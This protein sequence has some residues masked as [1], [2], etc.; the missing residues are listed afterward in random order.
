MPVDGA[1]PVRACIAVGANQGDRRAQ[2]DAA[3]A[4]LAEHPEISVSA[5]SDWMETAPVGPVPQGDFINGAVALMTT[6]SAEALLSFCL[7]IEADMGRVRDLRWGPRVID[8]DL[9][10]YGD[11]VIH[12]DGLIVPHPEMCDRSFVMVPLA[13]VAPDQI[14]PVAGK[15]VAG[16]A[17]DLARRVAVAG[18]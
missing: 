7:C 8:L 14:H 1:K 15:T 2:C 5:V 4:R 17:A 16:L 18:G 13:Q 11:H 6:L 3:V 9:L 10:L 12:S